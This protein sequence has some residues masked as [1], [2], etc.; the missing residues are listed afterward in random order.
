LAAARQKQSINHAGK[1]TKTLRRAQA[2]T[3]LSFLRAARRLLL[4]DALLIFVAAIGAGRG[5]P[6]SR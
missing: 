6:T 4:R 2:S 3:S 1:E 5:I